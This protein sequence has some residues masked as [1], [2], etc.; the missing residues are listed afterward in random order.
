MNSCELENTLNYPNFDNL[1]F[2]KDSSPIEDSILEQFNGIYNI[3]SEKNIF[4]KI[5][6]IKAS[7]NY[8]SFFCEANGSYIIVKGGIKDSLLKFEGYWRLSATTNT[9]KF[10]FEIPFS[11]LLS[12]FKNGKL[13]SNFTFVGFASTPNG[14]EEKFTFTFNKSINNSSKH[15]LIIARNCCS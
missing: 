1:D 6:V 9:G 2:L 15:L 11:S 12:N 3:T 10:T 7:S 5:A 8:L 4:G 13:D 14:K